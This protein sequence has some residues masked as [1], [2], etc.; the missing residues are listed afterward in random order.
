MTPYF[1]GIRPFCVCCG[2]EGNDVRRVHVQAAGPGRTVVYIQKLA[3][4]QSSRS[5]NRSTQGC[6]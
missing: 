2:Q 1:N 5:S 4:R 6:F 3:P